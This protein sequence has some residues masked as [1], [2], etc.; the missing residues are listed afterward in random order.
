MNI[1]QSFFLKETILKKVTDDFSAISNNLC[2]KIV[3]LKSFSG[4]HL[5][6]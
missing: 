4:I 3:A 5:I 6:C 1:F 2:G